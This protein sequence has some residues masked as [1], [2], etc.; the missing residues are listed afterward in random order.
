M[1]GMYWIP[2]LCSIVG[3]PLALWPCYFPFWVGTTTAARVEHTSWAAEWGVCWHSAPRAHEGVLSRVWSGGPW[4]SYNQCCKHVKV[5]VQSV[6][7]PARKFPRRW[8]QF[9]GPR[10]PFVLALAEPDLY[11][12]TGSPKQLVSSA[13]QRVVI[14]VPDSLKFVTIIPVVKIQFL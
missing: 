3:K 5:W 4:T 13:C 9:R 10:R 12:I 7:S 8:I 14:F 6:S 1:A 2:S 11:P